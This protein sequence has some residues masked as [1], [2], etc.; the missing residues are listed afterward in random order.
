MKFRLKWQSS[1]DVISASDHEDVEA[2]PV[3]MLKNSVEVGWGKPTMIESEALLFKATLEDTNNKI[4]I[5]VSDSCVP[6]YNFGYIYK[7]IMSSPRSFVDSGLHWLEG[8][9]RLLHMIRG[10]H[11]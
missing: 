8:M 11:F 1:N 9:Q 6:L 5:L 2:T 7:Y 10:N 4:F 3:A